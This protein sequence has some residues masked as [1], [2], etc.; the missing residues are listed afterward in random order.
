MRH[1][2]LLLSALSLMAQAPLLRTQQTLAVGGEGGWDYVTVDAQAKRIYLPRGTHTMVLDFEGKVIGDLTNTAGVH[3]VALAPELDRGFTSNGR[4][5]TMTIFKLSTLEVL[6]EVKTTGENP[7]AILFDPSTKRVFTFNGRG[8][9]VT[10]FDAATGAVV[11]TLPVG[12]KPEFAVTDLK[13]HV[14]VNVEDTHEVLR[15]DA[16]KLAVEKRWSLAPLEEPTGMAM[17][18]AHQRLFIVGG[19]KKMAIVNADTGKVITTLPVGEG[20]DAAAFDAAKGLIYSSNGEGTVTVVHQDSPDAYRVL[21][22]V[23][24]K[25]GA[26]T[27]GL[28]ERTHRLYLPFA[29]FEPAAAPAAENPRPRPKM[30]PGSFQVLVMAP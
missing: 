9:N 25:K 11:G 16:I 26:R 10:V 27:M 7:D 19:N 22:Q 30:A 8:K 24:T 3:G 6:Q 28:D 29:V 21:G 1:V 14:Y 23:P 2:F 5:G 13:G 12:G 15:L 20:A 4:A 18:V 17:D